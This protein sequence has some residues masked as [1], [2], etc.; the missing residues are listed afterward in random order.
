MDLVK[1][2]ERY[3]AGELHDGATPLEE[4]VELLEFFQ[5]LIDTNLAWQLQGTYGRVAARLVGLGLC[6][7]RR[8][9]Q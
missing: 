5:A 7:P 1:Q 6:T 4:Q 8:R 3:E 9:K 2:I